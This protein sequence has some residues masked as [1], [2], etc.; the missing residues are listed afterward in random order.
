MYHL[1]GVLGQLGQSLERSLGHLG[2]WWQAQEGTHGLAVEQGPFAD[3]AAAAVATTVA[4][5]TAA[6]AAC[7]ELTSALERAQIC[8]ADLTFAEPP[9]RARLRP[10]GRDRSR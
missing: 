2:Q 8:T 4:S 7:T 1:M 5:L 9:A 6:A 10:K 3:D